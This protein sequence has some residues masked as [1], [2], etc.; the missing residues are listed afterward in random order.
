MADRRI[1][2]LLEFIGRPV[3]RLFLVSCYLLLVALAFIGKLTLQLI[4]SLRQI[5]LPRI[6]LPRLPRIPIP[7]I[8]PLKLTLLSFSTFML[9]S[10][11]FVVFRG[12]PSPRQLTTRNQ[13][14]TTKIRARDGTVLFKIYKDENR[15]LIPLSSIPDFMTQATIAIE[16][17]DFY[18]NG[19]VTGE[20]FGSE[21]LI[22]GGELA[23]RREIT[24]DESIKCREHNNK[25]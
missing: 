25:E 15:S 4:K 17:K 12:L 8:S 7:K 1:F 10:F 6:T 13:V 2:K 16:D 5:K 21:N 14:L 9:L 3:L 22:A 19:A 20:D 11:Y 18:Q 24:E 23:G